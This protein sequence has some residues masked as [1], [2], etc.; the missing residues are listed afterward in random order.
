MGVCG[1]AQETKRGLTTED[2][3]VVAG[4]TRRGRWAETDGDSL[5][6]FLEHFPSVKR[7]QT[8]ALL[9]KVRDRFDVTA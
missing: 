1:S 3:K 7:E 9:Y 5:E 4:K 6:R 8:V 2:R